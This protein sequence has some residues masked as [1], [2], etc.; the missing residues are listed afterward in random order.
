M[1]KKTVLK[2]IDN[3]LDVLEAKIADTARLYRY[4]QM[5]NLEYAQQQILELKDSINKLDWQECMSCKEDG[6]L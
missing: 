1:D 4:G 5:I 3:K 2:V 6:Y